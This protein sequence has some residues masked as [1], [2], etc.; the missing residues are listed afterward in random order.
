MLPAETANV[1]SKELAEEK[2][3]R[4]KKRRGQQ[5]PLP[6]IGDIDHNHTE[7][8]GWVDEF[9]QA[10]YDAAVE[11]FESNAIKYGCKAFS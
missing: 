5:S 10:V 4:K 6:S 8:N 3:K 11:V 1:R 7:L 9:D 2:R